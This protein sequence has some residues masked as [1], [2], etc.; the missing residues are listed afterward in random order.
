MRLMSTIESTI[1]TQFLREYK[2]I[3]LHY[4]LNKRGHDMFVIM[5]SDDI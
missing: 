1:Y 3:F 5:K 4:I 2:Y